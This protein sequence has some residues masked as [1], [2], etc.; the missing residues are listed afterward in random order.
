MRARIRARR[1]SWALRQRQERGDFSRSLRAR[2]E[3]QRAAR[4]RGEKLGESR[5]IASLPIGKREQLRVA[6]ED[7]LAV[8]DVVAVVVEERGDSLAR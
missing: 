7:M 6:L 1:E 8:C 5:F 3:R 4:A 2:G